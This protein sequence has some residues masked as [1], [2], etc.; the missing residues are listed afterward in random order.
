M[1]TTKAAVRT[2]FLEFSK[3]FEGAIPWIYLDVKGLATIGLGCLIEPA[4]VALGLPFVIRG[5]DTK[6]TPDQIARDWVTVKRNRLL[7]HQGAQRARFHT[8]LD[9][10]EEG[11]EQLAWHRLKLNEDYLLEHAFPMFGE[12]PADAQLG[13]HSMCWAMGAGFPAFFPKFTKAAQSLDWGGCA[14]ECKMNA[15]NNPGLVPRNWANL[16]LFTKLAEWQIAKAAEAGDTFD[17]QKLYC[18]P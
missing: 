5:T 4:G 13:I 6:A 17:P 1:T 16:K 7:A 2:V 11:I 18:W 3:K 12:F 14:K 10:T 8:D 9:L 15:K